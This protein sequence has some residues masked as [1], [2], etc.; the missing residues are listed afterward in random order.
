MT[1]IFALLAAVSLA[2]TNLTGISRGEDKLAWPQFRGPGGSGV[3]DDQQPPVELG[4]DKNVKWK[5][6]VP[7]GISSPIVAGNLIVIIAF[8]DDKLYTIAYERTGGKEAW[9]AQAQAKK[10]ESFY[11]S[12][13]SPAAS[14]CATDGQRIVSYFGSCCRTSP[15]HSSAAGST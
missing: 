4:P 1:R 12:E 8:E 14:T 2:A 15:R 11:K 6:A 5:I 13:G 9:R 7:S 10:I 3:A